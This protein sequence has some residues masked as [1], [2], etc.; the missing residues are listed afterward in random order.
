MNYTYARDDEVTPGTIQA[1][2]QANQSGLTTQ[3]L[4]CG[5]PGLIFFLLFCIMRTRWTVIFA[6]RMSMKKRKPPQL[7]T[8]FLGWLIPLLRISREQMLDKVGLD[9]VIML[10]FI[11]M[12]IKIFG[13]CSFFGVVVLVPISSTRG[14]ATNPLI[15]PVDKASITVIDSQSPYLIAY[16]VFAYFFTIVTWF[17]LQQNY[18]Q[19]VCVRSQYLLVHDRQLVTRSVLITGLP[20]QLRSDD[21]LRTYFETMIGVGEVES[22]HVMRYVDKIE[23]LV[24]KRAKV[25]RK[26]ERAYCTYLGNP[27]KVPGYDPQ[28]MLLQEAARID[29]D[30][31]E[32]AAELGLPTDSSLIRSKD[33]QNGGTTVII[34]QNEKKKG[35]G[36]TTTT[37]GD[38]EA[39][40]SVHPGEKNADESE[41]VDPLA[42]RKR[43]TIHTGFLGLF[44]P[45]TDAITY[46]TRQFK[47]IDQKTCDAR[48]CNDLKM[49]SV[50]YVTFK[51]M[52]SALLAS[53]ITISPIP[54]QCETH[55][56][57]EPRDI[58]N[59]N[60]H[61][62]KAQRLLRTT[63]VWVIT[64]FL[65]LFWLIPI[66]FISSFT[67]VN[68]IIKYAPGLAPILSESPWIANLL[69]SIVPTL[70]VNIFM[71]LL[72]IVFDGLGHLQGLRS[73][74]AVAES[75]LSKYFFF[76]IF[77]VL[78][79]FTVAST[80]WNT[81][82]VLLKEPAQI[83]Q[84]LATTLP[85]VAPFFVNYTIMQALLLKPLQLL[86]IGDVIVRSFWIYVLAKTPREIS[87]A[88]APNSFNYGAGYPAP[89]L[90]FVIVLEYS[91]ISP[92]ILVAGL[93][94]FCITYLVCKY[95]FLYVY[96]RPYEAAGRLWMLVFPRIIAGMLL[97]QLTMI[98]LF[99]LK[100][101]LI[102][103]LM[104]IPLL[105]MTVI[106]KFS[107]DKAYRRTA[108]NLPIQLLRQ[109]VLKE[110]E[111]EEE[112]DLG[113]TSSE[114]ASHS[115]R[116]GSVV[117]SIHPSVVAS[118]ADV[119][120]EQES[121]ETQK[122]S[123]AAD[124]KEDDAPENQGDRHE[125]QNDALGDDDE[126]AV[127][128]GTAK[129]VQEDASGTANT[130]PSTPVPTPR[131]PSVQNASSTHQEEEGAT[132]T[133][134][135][136]NAG[137]TQGHNGV[138]PRR[139]GMH[140]RFTDWRRSMLQAMDRSKPRFQFYDQGK[141]LRQ[142]DHKYVLD[143]DN[144]SAFPHKKT[145]HREPPMNL[146]PGVLDTGLRM[147][148][149]PYL[150]GALPQPWLPVKPRQDS[151]F[152][153][154][155][156]APTPRDSIRHYNDNRNNYYDADDRDRASASPDDSSQPAEKPCSVYFDADRI[157]LPETTSVS[158]IER[159]LSRKE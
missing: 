16:L 133:A 140:R 99:I 59:D 43:P 94:Y 15:S 6:P 49:T 86:L 35:G 68:T 81:L 123:K 117:L 44:G 109:K 27:C 78:L 70:L 8:S 32:D 128:N 102:L 51:E 136:P 107:I 104:V 130:S 34:N 72:P 55:E 101:S 31:A 80:V 28:Q 40:D 148:A 155:P 144:Y 85:K 60:I 154:A 33:A 150:V 21:A 147:Y 126:Q 158:H 76:L 97:F 73:R 4:I 13:L 48:E 134:V 90:I 95:Q 127:P 12:S 89:L 135:N 18:Q 37:T 46:Y 93:V 142:R 61:I 20:P 1:S 52:A 9:A 141:Q 53:Q 2:A 57:K 103:G 42:K 65:V 157:S 25:L 82:L 17:F 88:R 87:A 153:L 100:G 71:A 50:A 143:E 108:K 118:D 114:D 7:P 23:N 120:E 14:N 45:K 69:Q 58:L 5:V 132:T 121:E 124:G 29:P 110:M 122:E 79:V 116:R 3:L 119:S 83:A 159:P 115:S 156:M 139:P 151:R 91:T 105:V 152:T 113:D 84:L 30:A 63:L 129:N 112:C 56:A 64:V 62:G 75:T 26:L 145:D 39:I 77:N 24:Q 41:P 19:Y 10:D 96:F 38:A 36:T 131:S 54:F 66:A 11:M 47:E 125:T 92:I 67:S 146:N 111:M 98:G 149:N 74:S 106:Y 137:H 138:R 22:V